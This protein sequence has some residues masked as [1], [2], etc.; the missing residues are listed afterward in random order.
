[1]HA[2][3][4]IAFYP[5]LDRNALRERRVRN[6]QR[7]C[8]KVRTPAVPHLIEYTDTPQMRSQAFPPVM[9]AAG[10]MGGALLSL[11]TMAIAG[12]QLSAEL[13]TFQTLFLRSLI[14]L[15]IIA[16]VLQRAGWAQIKT[17][18]FGVHLGRN[19]AHFG[20]QYGWFYAIGILPLTEV[21]A[22]EFTTPIWTAIL[23]TLFLGERMTSRRAFAVALGFI[24]TLII[25]RP[26]VQVVS[27]AAL[28][29]LASAVCYAISYVLMKRLSSTETP[30]CILFYM[31][32][33]QLPL[34]TIP[35]LQH[36]VWPS[37]HLW[38]WIVLLAIVGLT[39]HYC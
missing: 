15:V 5:T 22:I 7:A 18:V 2:S 26:G 33:I 6:G 38:P 35:A 1:M 8:S 19:I 14:G 29:V 10:W 11:L 13:I 36:W 24:G 16:V 17:R 30:L 3:S 31:S 39:A 34:S 23:A 9:R 21:F 27:L 28:A 12:R 4:L 20:G 32:V 37:A 25:L